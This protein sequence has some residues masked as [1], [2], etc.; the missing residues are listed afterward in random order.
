[1]TVARQGAAEKGNR[2]SVSRGPGG[3]GPFL[4]EKSILIAQLNSLLGAKY[5]KFLSL[6]VCRTYVGK[7]RKRHLYYA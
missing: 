3:Q 7:E 6:K 1:M 2:G 5:A 4:R